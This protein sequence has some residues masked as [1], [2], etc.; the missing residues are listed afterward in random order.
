LPKLTDLYLFDNGLTGSI[1]NFN[2]PELTTLVLS[3]NGLEGEIP[4]FTLPKSID[5]FLDNN[6]L[7]GEI[8]VLNFPFLEQLVLNNNELEGELPN[9]DLPNLTKLHL[10]NNQL[11]GCY[12]S[13]S[14]LCDIIQNLDL[15]LSN[16]PGLPQ[17][18]SAI[19]FANYCDDPTSQFGLPCDDGDPTTTGEF[20]QADCNCSTINTYNL[21]TGKIFFD[22]VEDC[23][24][25]ESANGLEQWLITASD[26]SHTYY[27][28]SDSLGNYEIYVDIGSYNIHVAL[29][30][31]YWEICEL[32][33]DSVVTVDGS[34]DS[35]LLDIPAK[36]FHECSILKVDIS[37]PFLRRCFDNT[38]YVSYCNEGTIVSEDSYIEI[39]FDESL[40]INS[41]TLPW[42]NQAGQLFTF[43]IGDVAIGD[44]GTFQVEVFLD[45]D[46]T[47][48]GE[49]HCVEAHAYPDSI[50]IPQDTLWD[51]STIIVD[52]ECLGNSMN[53]KIQ[54]DGSDMAKSLNYII[55]EDNIILMVDTFQLDSS[56]IKNINI[57]S[58]GLTYRLEA[59]QAA[60]HPAN[61]MPSI[62]IERCATNSDTISLGFVNV[63]EDDDAN[64]F[65]SID[66]QENVGSWD[67]NDK[68][69]FPKGIGEDH[70][71]FPETELE[72]HIRFQNTGT[73]TAFNIVIGDT[74]A[75][76]FLDLSSIRMG[77]S[78]HPYSWKINDTNI[79]EITFENIMLPDSNTNEVASHGFV[80]FK[81]AQIDDNP[82]GIII[83]NT[84]GIYFDFNDP[85]ITN[86][87][88]HTIE[89]KPFYLDTIHMHLCN[90]TIYQNDT[91]FI[92]TGEL[93]SI[94]FEITNSI[95]VSTP[96]TTY[97]V[98]TT[99]NSEIEICGNIYVSDA[100]IICEH[101]DVNGCD[102]IVHFNLQFTTSVFENDE[103]LKS[104]LY[105]YPNPSNGSFSL[106]LSLLKE[107]EI[108]I[109]LYNL[110]GQIV[111]DEQRSI[112]PNSQKQLIPV[113]IS[114]VPDGIYL[115]EVTNGN[116]KW[117]QKIVIKRN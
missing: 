1:P 99:D 45:C 10:N 77:V 24:Y 40:T 93:G 34:V 6:N 53:F 39:Y 109:R 83:E 9:F 111:Y 105:V 38:Y 31:N 113:S 21:I 63:Y 89:E 73:D 103:E 107:D 41:S 82:L 87:T 95:T 28:V 43:D 4:Y 57:A 90:D 15:S 14:N 71:I 12:S 8:P 72:Y 16:N 60:N 3:Q 92:S 59:E 115:L 2:L 76:E 94:E 104:Q 47:I 23:E 98:I 50:C 49:T 11:S 56:G 108:S 61:G 97:I 55:I 27:G 30:N 86:T 80:K 110:M 66:C 36:A 88:M 100:T 51:G 32:S 35:L 69:G 84:A 42:S 101:I 44:C 7:S 46:S 22:E 17:G 78:S 102:S 37:T 18:G 96:D 112:I 75:N 91:T 116:S 33:Q 67:P 54:N 74:L 52:G 70:I 19:A 58:T 106:K 26:S 64:P 48:L 81:L 25:Y 65:V 85:V 20:I 62:T 117:N 68:R 114:P 5:L 79:L 29:P 13:S